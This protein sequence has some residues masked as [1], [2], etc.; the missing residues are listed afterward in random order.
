MP[1]REAHAAPSVRAQAQTNVKAVIGRPSGSYDLA[2]LSGT[3]VSPTTPPPPPMT[4]TSGVAVTAKD[5]AL[6]VAH[7]ER[8][9]AKQAVSVNDA[10]ACA[11]SV[12]ARRVSVGVVAV[13]TSAAPVESTAVAAQENT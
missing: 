2:A 10:A 1:S 13:G 11:P 7:S 6:E 4:A 9:P 12:R 3:G 5:V 8:A